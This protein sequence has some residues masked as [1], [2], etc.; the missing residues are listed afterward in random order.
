MTIRLYFDED[1][2]RHALVQ[3]LRARGMDVVTALEARMIERNDA[4]HLDFATSHGRALF[5]FNVQDFYQLHTR[6][7]AEGK[8]H[9][10]L[11]LA[12]QQAYSVGELMR[13]L[14]RLST[15]KTPE[16]LK[17]TVEFLSAWG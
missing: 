15:A 14:L 8:T 7:M 12:R 13:R 16:Q 1:S 3:A 11:I 5:S 9:A 6:Y 2:M 4:E 17:N 10:G